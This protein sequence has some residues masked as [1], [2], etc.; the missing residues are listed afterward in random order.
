M[1]TQTTQTTPIVQIIGTKRLHKGT[2]GQIGERAFRTTDEMTDADLA[3][4]TKAT[5]CR[6]AGAVALIIAAQQAIEAPGVSAPTQ[7]EVDGV[8]VAETRRVDV[9][10]DAVLTVAKIKAKK[11]NKASA[12]KPQ[13]C[14]ACAETLPANKFPTIR[15]G[16]RGTE[17][18]RC[19]DARYAAAK[20]AKA[21]K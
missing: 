9:N 2:C 14:D 6:P 13:E 3:K 20:A 17:C 16:G 18:R 19:R 5:C 8:V 21:A 1:T 7:V 11:A 12:G 4:A 15:G 10:P